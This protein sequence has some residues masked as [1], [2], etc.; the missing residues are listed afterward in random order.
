MAAQRRGWGGRDGTAGLPIG[1]IAILATG[2]FGLGMAVGGYGTYVTALVGRGVAPGVAGAGMS[3]FLLGQV[4]VVVP[5]DRLTRSWSPVAVVAVGFGVATVGAALGGWLSL[6]AALASRTLLGF[7]QAT[8]FIG[9][10]KFVARRTHGID[11]AAAQGFLGAGFT[12]GFAVGMAATPALFDLDATVPALAAAAVILAGLAGAAT[13]EAAG[14]E[15]VQSLIAYV[16][17]LRSPAAVMLGLA[18]MAAFG[19]MMVAGTWYTQLLVE[20]P[21]IATTPALVG[22]ALAT[23]VGRSL[24]GVAARRV[25]SVHTVGWSLVGLTVLLGGIGVGV[26]ADE[27]LVL[28]AGVVL[29][30]LAFGLPFGPL[31]SLAFTELSPDAGVTL[32]GML[33]IGN[34]G[35]LAFPWLVGRLLADTA[36]FAPGFF[37][38]AF[39][40]A[41]ITVGWVLTVRSESR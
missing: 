2:L 29:T 24:G 23:V 9:A 38:M 3:L 26:A 39:S 36:S 15:P 34:I 13:L 28:L 20:V 21:A 33:A 31:F 32:V 41:A 18:N 6:P 37:V 17:A 25:G 1:P 35:A 40:V 30:G 19:F 11:T 12:L 14:T 22:F 7:G 16:D 5:A 4:L 10:M 8:A 27:P